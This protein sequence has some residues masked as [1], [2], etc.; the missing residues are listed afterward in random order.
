MRKRLLFLIKYYLWLILI[1]SMGR[2]VFLFY[3]QEAHHTLSDFAQVVIHGWRLDASIIGYMA[4]LPWLLLLVSIPFRQFNFRRIIKPYLWLVSFI[5]GVIL[6]VDTSLYDFWGFKLDATIFNYIDSP[7]NAAASVSMGFII[8]RICCI[9]SVIALIGFPLIRI[10]PQKLVKPTSPF[11]G[12]TCLILIGGLMFIGIR[13]G[14]DRSTANVGMAYFS[15]EQLLNHAAINP[16]FSLFYSMGKQQ[17]FRKMYHELSEQE[18]KTIF[19]SLY[20]KP[21]SEDSTTLVLK[22]NRPNILLIEWEGFGGLISGLSS[23][24]EG[25]TPHFNS[26][27]EEGIFFDNYYSNS[28]RT[29][30]GTLSTISGYPACPNLSIMKMPNISQTLPSIARKLAEIGYENSFLYGGD[31]NFTNMKSYLFSAGYSK[32]FAQETFPKKQQDNAWGVNDEWTFK[33]LMDYLTAL[34]KDKPWHMGYLTLSSHE[35]WDVPFDKYQDPIDNS[36]A[37]TDHCLGNFINQLKQTELWNNLLVIIL[38]DH[39]C[40]I[41]GAEFA[42]NREFFHC[43]MLWIGGAIQKPFHFTKHMNQ[44]D[45]AATIAAQLGLPTDDFMFSRNVF[46]SAYNNPFAFSCFNDGFMFTDS[47]G[48]IV[49]D[50][51][52]QKNIE[53]NNPEQLL[54]GKAI[55]QTIYDDLAS[56][57]SQI[58]N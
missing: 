51:A 6:I 31:I 38:P 35:P 23:D 10:A 44:S 13:G 52:S 36:F 26:L 21:S 24:K 12:A 56:R 49:Y 19:A 1:F 42:N 4:I 37:Y 8:V 47:S 53:G 5:I 48:T 30:R 41:P 54:K 34:P 55:L 9:L 46:S 17:D 27:I 39:C 25:I 57:N 20:E 11:R 7:K 3:N 16:C 33:W 2:L 58:A 32:L 45:V 22:T 40:H 28:F 29:D 43:P 50:H 15:D 14:V 18:C